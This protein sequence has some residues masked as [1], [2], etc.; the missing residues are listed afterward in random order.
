MNCVYLGA[1][2][3]DVDALLIGNQFYVKSFNKCQQNI[4]TDSILN[5]DWILNVINRLPKEIRELHQCKL[6]K[7][8]N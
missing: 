7:L 4:T 6:L 3:L 5:D 8:I 2:L 1:N